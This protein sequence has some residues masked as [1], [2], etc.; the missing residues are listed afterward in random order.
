MMPF[1]QHIKASYRRRKYRML[2]KKQKDSELY[3]PIKKNLPEK[4]V[5]IMFEAYFKYKKL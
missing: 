5:N 2:E 3:F 4:K 1:L